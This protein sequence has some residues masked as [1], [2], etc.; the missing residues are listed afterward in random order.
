MTGRVDPVLETERLALR[1]ITDG[2][3]PFLLELLTDPS[4]L[5]FIGDRGVQS[6]DDARAYARTG[7]I[8]SYERHGFGLW[9]TSLK[10]DE[11]PIGLC[12]LLKR[13]SLDDVDVGF[14]FLPAFWSRGYAREAVSAVL[15]SAR[16][17]Y[18]L[19]R[20]VAVVN[21][22][23]ARSRKLLETVGLRFEG[24]IQLSPDGPYLELFG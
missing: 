14:A 17:T 23:N 12:G 13:E 21:P 4:F 24:L 20:V 5:R 9:L 2:D 19:A 11:T 3:A 10:T 15:S 18:G 6:L 8:S 22:D 1:R 7:P 16:D